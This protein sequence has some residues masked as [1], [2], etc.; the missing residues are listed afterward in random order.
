MEPSAL[1]IA[2]L[3]KKGRQGT[4][5]AIQ[6]TFS[7]FLVVAILFGG[8]LIYKKFMQRTESYSQQADEIT[9]TEVYVEQ[10][11]DSFFLGVKLFSIKIG[12]SKESKTNIKDID[13]T[14]TRK[15]SQ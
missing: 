14:I 6:R 1:L 4:K 11:E 8:Y 15:G 2:E 12:I 10:P 3:L 13:K 9:N 7:V 5:H